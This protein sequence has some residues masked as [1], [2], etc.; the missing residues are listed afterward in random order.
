MS[1]L[2]LTM[3][4]DILINGNKDISITRSTLQDDI[5]QVYLRLMTEPNDF[6][7]YPYLG[8]DLSRLY[9]NATIKR[10]WRIWQKINKS[11]FG[12]RRRL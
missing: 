12:K 10:D 5:Q 3:S 11:S 4:G 8:T 1:D 2:F 7:I 9:R 6:A